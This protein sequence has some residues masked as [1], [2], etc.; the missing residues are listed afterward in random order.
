MQ[1]LILILNAIDIGQMSVAVSLSLLSYK[2]LCIYG[3][4]E[5]RRNQF[6]EPEALNGRGSPTEL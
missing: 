4:M 1:M 5:L 3:Y 6:T 2:L